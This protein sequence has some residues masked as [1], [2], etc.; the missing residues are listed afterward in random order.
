MA[1]F[2]GVFGYTAY[3]GSK[4]ALTGFAECL[5][6]ELKPKGIG[7]SVLFPPDTDTPQLAGEEPLKPA[8]TRAIAGTIRPVSAELVARQYLNGIAAGRKHIHPGFETRVLSVVQRL[9]PWAVRRYMDG[10]V[11][12]A[13]RQAVR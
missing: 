5:R 10:Q 4:F 8:E 3:A 2:L 6:Q 9:A 12:R 13:A 7:V 1:G 11:R